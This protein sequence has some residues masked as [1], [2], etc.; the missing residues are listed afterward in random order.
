MSAT[1][2]LCSWLMCSKSDPAA[3]A[4]VAHPLVQQSHSFIVS[5][6]SSCD[7]AARPVQKTVGTGDSGAHHWGGSAPPPFRCSAAGRNRG[8]RRTFAPPPSGRTPPGAPRHP[9]ARASDTADSPT[10]LYSPL[11]RNAGRVVDELVRCSSAGESYCPTNVGAERCS[12][13]Q[14]AK[15]KKPRVLGWLTRV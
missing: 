5:C 9:A 4:G 8:P 2:K 13:K 3:S 10:T 6:T 14:H 7:L 11:A 12:R 1:L 15:S